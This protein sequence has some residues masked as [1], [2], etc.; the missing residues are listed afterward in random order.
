MIRALFFKEW[1]KS[2][3]A[4]LVISGVFTLLLGYIFLSVSRDIR[5]T[6]YGEVWEM[7]VQKGTTHIDLL[8]FFPLLAGIGLALMQY[9]PEIINK[10]LKLTLHLPLPEYQTMMAMLLFGIIY[11]SALFMIV[12]I[13]INQGLQVYFTKE[14]ARWNLEALTPWLWSGLA[15]YLFTAWICIEPVWKQRVLNGIIG[16]SC[17]SL[18]YFKSIPG[19]YAPFLPWLVVLIIISSCF[20]MYSLIRFKEGK[21]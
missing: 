17:L 11:L 14:V 10:R 20:S 12:Y 3:W 7:I 16:I 8:Q 19:A 2:R 5:V 9:I 21:Q 13:V 6:G 4:L 1:I 15:G 18:F